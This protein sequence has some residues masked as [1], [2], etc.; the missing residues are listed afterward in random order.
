MIG[1]GQPGDTVILEPKDLDGLIFN[2]TGL[3][4]RKKGNFVW[5]WQMINLVPE[6]IKCIVFGVNCNE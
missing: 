1:R 6:G 2:E 3:I 5:S 4:M